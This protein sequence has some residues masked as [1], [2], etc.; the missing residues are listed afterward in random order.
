MPRKKTGNSNSDSDRQPPPRLALTIPEFC[1]AHG[2]SQ[3]MYFKMK[4]ESPEST[5]REMRCG[6]RILI[7]LESAAEWRAAREAAPASDKVPTRRAEGVPA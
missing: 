7:S 5:P 1:E 4:R 6:A 2:F 3:A